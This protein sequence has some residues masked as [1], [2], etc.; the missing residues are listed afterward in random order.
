VQLIWEFYENVSNMG[1]ELACMKKF[2]NSLGEPGLVWPEGELARHACNVVAAS[3][4]NPDYPEEV[5]HAMLDRL[6]NVA[7]S[8]LLEPDIEDEID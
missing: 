3:G 6:E 5:Y 4:G 2:M 1:D 7:I 8:G